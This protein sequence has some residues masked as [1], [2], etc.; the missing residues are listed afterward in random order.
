[1]ITYNSHRYILLAD[2]TVKLVYYFLH[3]KI[4][5]RPRQNKIHFYFGVLAIEKY[6]PR[7]KALRCFELMKQ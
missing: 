2:I 4:L 1:M 5:P 7:G 6:T 3:Q